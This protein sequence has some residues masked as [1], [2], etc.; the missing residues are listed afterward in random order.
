MCTIVIST[1]VD[2]DELFSPAQ[3]ITVPSRLLVMFIIVMVDTKGSAPGEGTREN[4]KSAELIVI[5]AIVG[6]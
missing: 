4:V 6:F 3:L 5:G 2:S 1:I